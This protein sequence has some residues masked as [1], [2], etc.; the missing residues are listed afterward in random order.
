MDTQVIVDA[1]REKKGADIVVIDF[2]GLNE[3]LFSGFVIC[4]G[5]SS[6]QIEAIVDNI[7][8]EMRKKQKQHP[9]HI[10]GKNNME[11]VLMDYGDIIVHVFNEESRNFYKLED[12][13][14]DAIVSRIEDN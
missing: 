10:E 6:P 1:I 7:D 4:H 9:L 2:S 11:W 12:L 3:V 13:W 14:A 5:T 8:R